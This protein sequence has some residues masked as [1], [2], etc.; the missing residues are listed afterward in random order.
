ML[1]AAAHNVMGCCAN[2]VLQGD[3]MTHTAI[4]THRV[5]EAI[6][7]LWP[8]T[9]ANVR[10]ADPAALL[11]IFEGADNT[12]DAYFEMLTQQ[13]GGD[14]EG[15]DNPSYQAADEWADWLAYSWGHDEDCDNITRHKTD[16]TCQQRQWYNNQVWGKELY[17]DIQYRI[18]ELNG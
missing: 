3:T 10:E 4:K 5:F 18:R 11:D 16:C 2:T 6:Q 17:Q 13:F 1:Y 7:G 12:R 15:Y 14:C 8:V 9:F